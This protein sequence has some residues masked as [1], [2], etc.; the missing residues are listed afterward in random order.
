MAS[1]GAL[2]LGTS[3]DAFS[4]RMREGVA[5]IFRE[6][7]GIPDGQPLVIRDVQDPDAFVAVIAA[8]VP[9][10]V[11]AFWV[12]TTLFALWLSA[13]IVQGVEPPR[14][15]LA[16]HRLAAAAALDGAAS[17]AARPRRCSCPAWR[18]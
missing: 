10:L 12:L 17:S 13:R 18:G 14:P 11:V 7:M 4:A 6:Q 16:R 8:I 9:P 15:A 5:G 1:A 3:Y 2:T